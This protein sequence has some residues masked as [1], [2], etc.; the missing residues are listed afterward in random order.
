MRINHIPTEE[1]AFISEKYE[2]MIE[3]LGIM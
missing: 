2:K 3:K 1:V